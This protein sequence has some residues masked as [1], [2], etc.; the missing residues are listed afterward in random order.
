MRESS[1]GVRDGGRSDTY[2]VMRVSPI[3]TMLARRTDRHNIIERFTHGD[4]TISHNPTTVEY[5]SIS[6]TT[7]T[8]EKIRQRV[9]GVKLTTAKP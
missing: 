2:G 7:S 1:Q 6:A 4:T 8:V 9:G 3:S 5:I